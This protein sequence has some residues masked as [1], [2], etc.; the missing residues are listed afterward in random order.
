MLASA[1]DDDPDTDARLGT[2]VQ[3]VLGR[4]RPRSSAPV[5]D[6]FV[7]WAT[8]VG[9]RVGDVLVYSS[10]YLAAIAMT[11][12]A[13]AMLLLSIPPNPAPVVVGLVTFAVYSN[14][15]IADM[16]VDEISNPRQAAFVRRHRNVLYTLAAVAYGLALAL[17][18]LGGPM[19][20]AITLLPG[21]FWILYASDWVP[22]VGL[23]FRRLKELLIVNSAVVALAWAASLTFLPLAFAGADFSPA[24]ALV[25]GYFL[26]GTFGNTEIPNARDM[27]ADRAAGVR[28][29]PTEFGVERTRRILYVLDLVMIGA[30]AYAV[31]SDVIAPVL[32]GALILGLAYSLVTTSLLGRVEQEGLLTIAAE[33]EYLLVALALAPVVYGL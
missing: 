10:A 17:A 31:R 7:G 11:Q 28:T 30:L 14:D 25:F 27:A 22:D 3:R 32:A 4:S 1:K 26:L 29:M 24:A 33:S 9:D 15:H 8:A 19:A 20:L 5:L 12:V 13:I 23:H 6:R 2:P 21:G 16:D 18:A